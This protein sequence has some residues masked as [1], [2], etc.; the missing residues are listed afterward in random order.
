MHDALRLI[1]MF[2]CAVP[3]LLHEIC[4]FYGEYEFVKAQK[5]LVCHSLNSNKHLL[6]SLGVE[7]GESIKRAERALTTPSESK[8]KGGSD[9]FLTPVGTHFVAMQTACNVVRR[10]IHDNK[11]AAGLYATYVENLVRAS[12]LAV[13]ESCYVERGC[14]NVWPI[15]FRLTRNRRLR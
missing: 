15:G 5:D 3:Q 1:V 6:Q 10:P 14:Q 7:I 4:W 9:S 12:N 2:V 8:A 13:V 11:R